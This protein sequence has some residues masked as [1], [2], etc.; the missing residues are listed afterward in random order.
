MAP[1]RTAA[2]LSPRIEVR[3]IALPD[4]PR[5]AGG[6]ALGIYEDGQLYDAATEVLP[7]GEQR[8]SGFVWREMYGRARRLRREH[9]G[10][11][12]GPPSLLCRRAS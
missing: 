5:R 7:S 4:S 9:A 12:W 10:G 8:I 2:V 1:M 3:S 11:T 6:F